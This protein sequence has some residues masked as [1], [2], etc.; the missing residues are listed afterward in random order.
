MYSFQEDDETSFDTEF[1]NQMAITPETMSELKTICCVDSL[2]CHPVDKPPDTDVVPS[3]PTLRTLI[4]RKKRQDY[5]DSLKINKIGRHDLYLDELE[6]LAFG[7]KPENA[8]DLLSEGELILGINVYYPAVFERSKRERPHI[9]LSML[10]SH[11][12]S[13]LRDAICCVSDLQVCGEF[14]NVPDMAPDFISKDLYKSAFF[15]FEGVFYN[16]MRSPECQ[17]IST[18][19]IEWAKSRNL[20]TYTQAKM[21]DTRLVDLKVKLGY[22]YLYCHQGDCEHL[23]IITDIRLSHKDDCLDKRL[24]PLLTHKH[25]VVTKKCS[26]CH[27]YIGRWVTTNDKLAP[28]DPCLFCSKCFRT[29]HYDSEGNK[30]GDFLAHPYADPG[31]FN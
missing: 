7:K 16:D 24:Y 13:D 3:N 28:K 10:G 26:V 27:V 20:P 12:L 2:R 1:E 19:V 29:L 25:R 21:E 11:Y 23:V 8:V 5:K 18:I 6:R 17:D 15:Y 30:L 22:P 31:A 14:S 9:T 4:Q